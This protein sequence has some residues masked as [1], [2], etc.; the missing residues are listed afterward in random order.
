MINLVTSILYSTYGRNSRN[1]YFKTFLFFANYLN[2]VCLILKKISCLFNRE[3]YRELCSLC[4]IKSE[5]YN[6]LQKESKNLNLLNF[7]RFTNLEILNNS[8]LEKETEI[9]DQLSTQLEDSEEDEYNF[10]FIDI[11]QQNGFEE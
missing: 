4:N 1:F 8:L 10:D 11:V 5:N 2:F 9:N 3:N 6:G 7:A